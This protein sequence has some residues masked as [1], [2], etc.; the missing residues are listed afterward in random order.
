VGRKRTDGP[1]A[2]ADPEPVAIPE[3]DEGTA[4]DGEPDPTGESMSVEEATDMLAE[5]VQAIVDDSLSED[6][7]EEDRLSIPAKLVL[8]DG[9]EIPLAKLTWE[10][11]KTSAEWK[12]GD[13]GIPEKGRSIDLSLR[14]TVEDYGVD[15]ESGTFT[16]HL[17]KERVLGFRL[18][19][20]PAEQ[21]SLFDR[22]GEAIPVDAQAILREHLAQCGDCT[23]SDWG[24][25]LT[26]CPVYEELDA[27]YPRPETVDETDEA[28]EAED[29]PEDAASRD[30]IPTAFPGLECGTDGCGDPLLKHKDWQSGRPGRCAEKKDGRWC[31][32]QAFTMPAEE[33]DAE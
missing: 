19:A 17:A 33:P 22:G 7:A 8:L 9:R 16:L 24:S 28:E 26:A 31:E 25:V 27:K 11:K 15:P 23:K 30:L 21:A 32:C 5:T 20:K 14:V 10:L 2:V 18:V 12:L 3:A 1:T 13:A 4:I 29:E 6:A